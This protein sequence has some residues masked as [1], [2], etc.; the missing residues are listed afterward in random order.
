VL[1][2]QGLFVLNIPSLLEDMK[3]QKDP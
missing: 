1:K 3:K 2:A